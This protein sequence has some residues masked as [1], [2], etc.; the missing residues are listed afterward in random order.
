MFTSARRTVL[1]EGLLYGCETGGRCASAAVAAMLHRQS[2]APHPDQTTSSSA[3]HGELAP[4]APNS[5]TQR[6]PNLRIGVSIDSTGATFAAL[7]PVT[8]ETQP[9]LEFAPPKLI[10]EE[11]RY[12]LTV[13]KTA[14]FHICKKK[15]GRPKTMWNH[16]G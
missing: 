16:K 4:Q 15:H 5:R 10:N 13:G 7:M 11:K 1:M 14:P 8:Y 3:T 12:M 9:M 6:S 2:K